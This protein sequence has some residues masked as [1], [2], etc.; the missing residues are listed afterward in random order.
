[1][2]KIQPSKEKRKGRS[3]QPQLQVPGPEAGK[4]LA[5]SRWGEQSAVSEYE[6]S[7]KV[8][9]TGEGKARP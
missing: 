5:E 4:H 7:E 6:L 8:T 1:M 2:A 9:L 3:L